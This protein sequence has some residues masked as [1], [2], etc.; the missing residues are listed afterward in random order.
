MSMKNNALSRRDFLRLSSTVVAGAALTACVPQQGGAP[1]MVDPV[2]EADAAAVTRNASAEEIDRWLTG[3]VPPDIAGDFKIMSW[4]DEGEIRKFLLHIEE[5]FDNFYPNMTPEVEW[6]IP[7]GEYWT[8]LPTLLAAG[9]PPDM[10]WQHQSRGKV[11][12]SKGWS[13]ELTDYINVWPPDGWP[14]DWWEASVATLSYQD[15]VYAIPYDWATHGIYVNRDIM[16]EITDYP[17]N[18]DWTYEDL[19]NLAAQATGETDEGKIFGLNFGTSSGIFN[20]LANAFGGAIFNEDITESRFN[21]PETIEAAQ[22]LWDLRWTDHSMATP[23][24]E[25]ASGISGEFAFVSGRVALH[26]ALNDVAFRFDEAIGD[27]FNWGVYP[28]PA[29][30]GG[31]F[32]FAGNS[33]WF[34]PTGSRYPDLAWELIRYGLSNPVLLPTTGVMGSMIVARKSFWEWG[35]PQGDLADQIPNY[36]EVFVDIPEANQ[37]T[38]PHF[39]EF[40]EWDVIW[41][42]WT[43]PIFV[44]GNPDI[45]GALLG[46]HEETNAFLIAEAE[47]S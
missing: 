21:L 39:P 24:D 4:E 38:F 26:R 47:N 19:R 2:E 42:K 5:F 30:P 27:K 33:G 34:I 12:P 46:L 17:V 29:G 8:K 9:N 28:M 36:K 15:K 10:A 40:Q 18:R 44:E 1:A 23:E 37:L 35:L 7:W 3:Q 20:L 14:D 25:Q 22:Y 6:G 31:Q 43:D 32:A 16:D 11:F 41:R 45:E 13:V